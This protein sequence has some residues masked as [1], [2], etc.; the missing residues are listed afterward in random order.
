[1]A[2]NEQ[3]PLEAEAVPE[4]PIVDPETGQPAPG[5]QTVS[6]A[7]GVIASAVLYV[8]ATLLSGGYEVSFFAF[9][10]FV[11]MVVG[12]L[13]P[14]RPLRNAGWALLISLVLSIVTLQEGVVCV[15]FALPLIVPETLIGALCGHTLRRFVRARN[16]RYLASS[17]TVLVGL[18]FQAVEGHFH[19]P[20]RH[21]VHVAVS[22]IEI[23]A[24]PETVFRTLTAETL[25][26]P[27]RFP[28]FVRV[29]LPIPHRL[30][31]RDPSPHGKLEIHFDQGVAYGKITRF[32]RGAELAFSIERYEIR[33]LPF[34]ITRLGRG[35][36]WG[37]K[38][39]R[40][41]DWLTLIDLGYRLE[42]TAAG[43]TRLERRTTFRRHLAPDFYFGFLQQEIVERGQMRLLELIRE[44]IELP[45]ERVVPLAA[46]LADDR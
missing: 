12:C 15:L 37:L 21:P 9:P 27:N 31:I 42:R 23:D 33:D 41:D 39:E 43:G 20:S 30:A 16:H 10:F 17:L 35:P 26:V 28:W 11:G 4:R 40:V 36:H 46:F 38:T 22:A 29:G 8:G 45:S 13:S 1:M 7:I 14:R 2:L 34:H 25:E 24:P 5:S 32:R 18:G 6:V 3:D 44:R 19:D